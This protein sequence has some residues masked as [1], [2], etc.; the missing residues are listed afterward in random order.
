VPSNITRKIIND[1]LEYGSVQTG[2]LG[3]MGGSL[4]SELAE[5]LN[6]SE[7][8]GFYVEDV[9]ANSG[10]AL[11]GLKKGDIIKK[12]DNIKI[13][14]FTDMK[15][16]LKTKQ[17]NDVVEVTYLRNNSLKTTKVTLAKRTTTNFG[18]VG[19]LKEPTKADLK[20]YNLD[21]GLKIDKL[22]ENQRLREAWIQ[23]GIKEGTIVT[24]INNQ[25]IYTIDDVERIKSE[26][27]PY[28]AVTVEIINSNGEKEKYYFQN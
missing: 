15:G 22:T 3:V 27:S 12:V 20:K 7:T 2:I 8:E 17:P 18:I 5:K 10:A 14:K 23:N 25:K 24:K 6:I 9:E 4:N 13:S 1:I 19:T 26:L 11:A 16:Y 28:E 21:Y